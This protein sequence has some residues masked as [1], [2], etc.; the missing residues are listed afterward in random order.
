LTGGAIRPAQ[1]SSQRKLG[2]LSSRSDIASSDPGLR[3]EDGEA[4]DQASTRVQSL[5]FFSGSPLR[6]V[7]ASSSSSF[8]LIESYM[9][10]DAPLSSETLVSPRLAESAAPAA[11]CC[12]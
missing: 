4:K 9:P 6:S 11:F 12:D 3:R 10:F 1:S 5:D 8:S 7:S 2:A